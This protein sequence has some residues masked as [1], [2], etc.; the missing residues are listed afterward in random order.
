MQLRVLAGCEKSGKFRKA[1]QELGHICYS[2]DLKPAEDNAGEW[3]IVGD[4]VDILH[5]H[6]WDL[7]LIH[8]PCTRLTRAGQ[9]WL[10]VPPRGKTRE[11]MWD[12]Y[13][14][15]IKLF[16]AVWN[17]P[18]RHLVIENPRMHTHA[19]EDLADLPMQVQSIHPYW[20]G[21]AAFKET[22]MYRRNLPEIKATNYL[23]PPKYGTAEYSK[24]QVILNEKNTADRAENRARTFNGMADAW[25][26][27]YTKFVCDVK[28]GKYVPRIIRRKP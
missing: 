22:L 21:H 19:V 18:V 9:R 12:D 1:V 26:S 24:W 28:E 11:Q 3:H 10:N 6:P 7:A 8:V 14:A 20:F 5:N 2:C 23:P 4:V 13:N 17:S 15:A 16:K 27:Q 25:A